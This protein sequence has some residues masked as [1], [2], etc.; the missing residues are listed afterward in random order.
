MNLLGRDISLT[1]RALFGGATTYQLNVDWPWI[2]GNHVSLNLLAAH[3]VRDDDV[4]G[5]E[6]KSDEITTWIGTYLGDVGR[7]RAGFS[8]FHLR[9]DTD[10]ITL[11]DDNTDTLLRL[12]VSAGYDTRDAW[13]NPH[14]GWDSELQVMR[15]GGFLGGDGNFWTTDVDVLRYQPLGRHTLALSGLA[16]VQSGESDVPVYLNYLMGGANSIRGYELT[17]LGKELSGDNQLILTAEYQHLIWEV[18]EVIVYGF[19]LTLGLEAAAFL[20]TGV[21]WNDFD[22]EFDLDHARTG[23]GFG[24]RPLF[25]GVGE[26]RLDLAFGSEGSVAFHVAT[27]PK[28]VA[29]RLRLR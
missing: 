22:S 4:R 28:M 17:E 5:F 16:S 29:Q 25:P 19:A 11:S 27:S 21:A 6:E 2:V 12:G 18:R 7:L 23:G 9:S 1:G 13:V 15:A 3:L 26:I 20:D 14:R 10:G 24:L 8:Y